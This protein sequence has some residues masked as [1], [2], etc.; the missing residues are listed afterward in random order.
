M[1]GLQGVETLELE[2]GFQWFEFRWGSRVEPDSDTIVCIDARRHENCKIIV[3]AGSISRS[4][5]SPLKQLCCG[6]AGSPSPCH[7]SPRTTRETRPEMELG[8]FFW[9]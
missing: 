3:D 2:E 9:D 6:L 7:A 1:P 5:I 8:C 4:F